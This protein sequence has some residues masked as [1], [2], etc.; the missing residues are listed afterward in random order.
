MQVLNAHVIQYVYL[1]YAS[2][3]C[4][5]LLRVLIYAMRYSRHP[6][7]RGPAACERH[8]R[9][10][11]PEAGPG[12]ACGGAYGVRVHLGVAAHV[13]EDVH[14]AGTHLRSRS[15]GHVPLVTNGRVTV[16]GVA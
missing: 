2:T 7:A 8:T 9:A 11:R 4:T 5:D 6:E 15:C 16:T 14:T 13:H 12:A 1:M 10:G 3:A